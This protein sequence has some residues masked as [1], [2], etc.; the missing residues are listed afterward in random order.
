MKT[1][2]NHICFF[3]GNNFKLSRF[4]QKY[5]ANLCFLLSL[6]PCRVN[7]EKNRAKEE[8]SRYRWTI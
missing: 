6:F 8:R 1:T 4:D 7:I 2:R 3:G 5:A